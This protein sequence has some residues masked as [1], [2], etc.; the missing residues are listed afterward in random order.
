MWEAVRTIG[1]PVATE[2][3]QQG[4]ISVL[5][6]AR[7]CVRTKEQR[8]LPMELRDSTSP[9]VPARFTRNAAAQV[10]CKERDHGDG[11]AKDNLED[12]WQV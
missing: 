6:Y 9:L 10:R 4:C 2:I 12:I 7:V 5:V 3:F 8:G 1:R 11:D